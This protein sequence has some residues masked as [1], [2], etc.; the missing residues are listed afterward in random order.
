MTES[1]HPKK[2]MK[3]VCKQATEDIAV[4][5][6]C[7]IRDEERRQFQWWW[8]DPYKPIPENRI[9]DTGTATDFK[10][11]KL[12]ETF[13][14]FN[15]SSSAFGGHESYDSKE[16]AS[17]VTG[18]PGIIPKG[19]FYWCQGRCHYI[20]DRLIL[21]FNELKEMS[22]DEAIEHCREKEIKE[23]G[24]CALEHK[25]LRIWLEE[26]KE[27]KSKLNKED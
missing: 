27:L 24:N 10:H 2:V 1:W 11:T 16:S 3:F 20:S 12:I 21:D 6:P 19:S 4:F 8:N 18:V 7:L 22:L 15:Y 13:Y 23:N 9:Y 14:A 26:L 25:Q 5:V 17:Y